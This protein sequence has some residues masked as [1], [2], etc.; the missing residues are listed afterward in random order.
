MRSGEGRGTP[1]TT[2]SLRGGG[3]AAS[4][5]ESTREA[6]TVPALRASRRL[7][8]FTRQMLHR[9]GDPGKRTHGA[10]EPLMRPHGCTC[11]RAWMRW[12]QMTISS[13]ATVWLAEPPTTGVSG[14]KFPG[15]PRLVCR[16]LSGSLGGMRACFGQVHEDRRRQPIGR[17]RFSAS[18]FR[19][20]GR[21]VF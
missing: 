11:G 5:L 21:G 10:P 2:A 9:S 7:S 8:G 17:P 16:T 1:P 12:T 14:T 6:V 18:A 4:R 19:L 20:L 3:N 13:K 15:N